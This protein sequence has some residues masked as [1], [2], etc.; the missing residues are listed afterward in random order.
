MGSTREAFRSQQAF[1]VIFLGG[2]ELSGAVARLARCVKHGLARMK[3][4]TTTQMA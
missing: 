1:G 3:T 2:R 4:R